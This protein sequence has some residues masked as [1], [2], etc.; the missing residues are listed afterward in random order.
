MM[1]ILIAFLAGCNNSSTISATQTSATENIETETYIDCTP[2]S[3]SFEDVIDYSNDIYIGRL[4]SVDMGT[5]LSDNIPNSDPLRTTDYVVYEFEITDVLFSGYN[6][7]PETIKIYVHDYRVIEDCMGYNPKYDSTFYEGYDYLLPVYITDKAYYLQ[8]VYHIGGNMVLSLDQEIAQYSSISG[9]HSIVTLN[10]DDYVQVVNKDDV[11]SYVASLTRNKENDDSYTR[12]TDIIK[13]ADFSKNIYKVKVVELIQT[14]QNDVVFGE[15]YTVSIL[16]I[17]KE[18]FHF[19]SGTLII[20]FVG[21][22]VEPGD[23]VYVGLNSG[24]SRYGEDG[25][26][27][28]LSSRILFSEDEIDVIRQHLAVT[29]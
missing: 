19:D 29:T 24:S 9:R 27:F 10:G 7:T 14:K 4:I 1:F 25:I 26:F 3:W 16:D 13:I 17:I 12:E 28:E 6:R 23:E 5:N 15:V 20:T 8:D 21:G 18:D 2:I 11:V 22:T